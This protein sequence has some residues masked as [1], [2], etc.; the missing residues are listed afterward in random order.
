M[1]PF[2]IATR[3][4]PDLP[5]RSLARQFVRFASVGATGTAVQYAVLWAGVEAMGWPAAASSALGYA[6]GSVVNYLLNY[7]F[8]FGSA[9][10]HVEAAAKYYSVLAV[11]LA[12]T[13]A[14]MALFVNRLGWNYWVAQL[15]TTGVAL[16][17][18]FAGSRW[19]AFKAHA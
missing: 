6:L 11:G 9:K 4:M 19:W 5:E 1:D 16:L 18:H 17:W 2:F 15:L 7:F 12:L 13:A 8:T 14:L 3:G 10:S